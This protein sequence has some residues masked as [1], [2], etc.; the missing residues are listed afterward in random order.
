MSLS[1]HTIAPLCGTVATRQS[2]RWRQDL[3]HTGDGSRDPLLLPWWLH[4]GPRLGNGGS[5]KRKLTSS[6]W[7]Q[8]LQL[9]MRQ[10]ARSLGPRRV[11]CAQP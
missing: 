6:P 3:G 9:T 5:G 4:G 2:P 7:L 1:S 10:L 11:P 8:L